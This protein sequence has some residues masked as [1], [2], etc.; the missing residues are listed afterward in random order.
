MFY[1]HICIAFLALAPSVFANDAANR[2]R[3]P[4]EYVN[5]NAAARQSA[6][7]E[8][9]RD[10][11]TDFYTPTFKNANAS[12][13]AVNSSALPLVSFPLQDSWAGRLP[14]SS[15]KSETKVFLIQSLD[16]ALQITFDPRNSS[17]GTGHQANPLSQIS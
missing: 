4:K 8:E 17:S 14:I 13:F 10:V 11:H 15:S 3:G 5:Q 1:K 6:Q 9:K 2:L 16:T 7:N 12:S